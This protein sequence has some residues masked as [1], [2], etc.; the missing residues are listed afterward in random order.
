MVVGERVSQPYRLWDDSST[1]LKNTVL[2]LLFRN[3]NHKKW[4]VYYSDEV[5]VVVAEWLYKSTK[6]Q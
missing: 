4:N 3:Q 2:L 1:K 5:V 6:S